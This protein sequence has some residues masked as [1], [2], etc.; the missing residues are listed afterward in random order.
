M[1]LSTKGNGVISR[2]K[3]PVDA[4]TEYND[5]YYSSKQDVEQKHYFMVNQWMETL[6]EI[7]SVCDY[8]CGTGLWMEAFEYFDIP[9]VGFEISELCVKYA[10][11]RVKSKIKLDWNDINGRFDLVLTNDV[12]EH[13]T[14]REIDEAI[15]RMMSVCNKWIIASICMIGDPNWHMDKT[16]IT[17]R[18]KEWWTYQFTK[19]GC[20]LVETPNHWHFG[21]QYL[22]F[23]V[24]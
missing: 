22:V 16:H 7:N 3:K 19:R 21:E 17:F 10:P 18:S 6:G 5:Y 2:N 20:I 13:L 23:K 4:P 12:L 15:G 11:E 9:A 14:E 24:R 8:G 1:K